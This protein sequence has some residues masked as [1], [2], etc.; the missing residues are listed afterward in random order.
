MIIKIDYREKELYTLLFTQNKEGEKYSHK[1]VS[2]NLPLGD[3]IVCDDA[4]QE[5]AIIER[6]TL[7]D[8][9]ASIRDGRYAEQSY[10][11][12]QCSL[13]N[14]NIFYLLEG[15]LRQYRPFPFAAG[16]ISKKA[17]LSA[18]TTITYFKGFSLQRCITLEES[19]DWLLQFA[20][21]IS[22]SEAEGQVAY[23]KPAET[24]L[25]DLDITDQAPYSSVV[26]NKRV[27]RDNITPANIGEIMLMQ[28]PGV[29]Q[30]VAAVIMAKYTSLQHLI[31]TLVKDP[32]ALTML[33]IANKTGKA[34]KVAKPAL[35]NIY[36]YLLNSPAVDAPA[37]V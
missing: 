33:T 7:K 29:S 5:K 23:Y 32:L 34:R 35:Q 14:H 1:I 22:K 25:T 8:L 16:G 18:M 31:E 28:I 10:R 37:A 36:T 27:K 3:I 30:T 26:A 15:D 4:G 19:A 17:L 6:K 24:A 9:A 21:K 11:L 20:S 2:E 13:P 12:Q